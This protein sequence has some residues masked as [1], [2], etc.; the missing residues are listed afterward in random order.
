MYLKILTLVAL[1]SANFLQANPEPC[2]CSNTNVQ[3]IFEHGWNIVE[4]QPQKGYA[5]ILK[6]HFGVKTS[7]EVAMVSLRKRPL[8]FYDDGW[9]YEFTVTENGQQHLVYLI[10]NNMQSVLLQRPKKVAAFFKDHPPVLSSDLAVL[11]FLVVKASEWNSS[12]NAPKMLFSP[13]GLPKDLV[14]NGLH[15]SSP[16]VFHQGSKTSLVQA[17]VTINQGVFSAVYEIGH[18]EHSVAMKDSFKVAN[19]ENSN[20]CTPSYTNNG[21]SYIDLR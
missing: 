8:A 4:T 2:G 5:L 10:N 14:Q 9:L 19:L 11:E 21:V 3:S 6:D 7:E 12:N 1:L 18:N 17:F 15:I 16:R 20:T 13:E